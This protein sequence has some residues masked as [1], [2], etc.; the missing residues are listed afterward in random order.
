MV[1]QVRSSDSSTAEPDA[2]IDITRETCPMTFVRTRL[3]IDRLVSGQLLL[4]RLCG[5]EPVLEVP[6]S[7]QELGHTVV[8]SRVEDGV[9]LLLLR[10]S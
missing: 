2:E 4:V 5:I 10:R 1:P 7:A 6:R 9:T 8:S 3:A